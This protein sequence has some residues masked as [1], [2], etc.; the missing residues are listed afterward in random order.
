MRTCRHDVCIRPRTG[1]DRRAPPGQRPERRAAVP[2]LDRDVDRAVERERRHDRRQRRRSGDPGTGRCRAG[3]RVRALDPAPAT[4]RPALLD[5]HG[6][7][8]VVGSIDM[9]HAFA[10]QVARGLGAVV[11]AVEY[12]LA[13]EHPFPAGVED[14]YAALQWMHDDAVALGIDTDRI[15]VGGQSAG[16]GLTAATVLLARDRG[17]PPVCFQFLGIPELDHRLETTSMRTFVDTPMWHRPNAEK[18]WRYYLGPDARR[19]LAVRV[20]RDR[21]RPQRAPAGLRDDHG[22]RPAPRRRHHL[23]V[24]DDGGGCVRGVALLPGNVPRIRGRADGRGL[25]PRPPGAPRRAPTRARWRSIDIARI[26]SLRRFDLGLQSAGG[27]IRPASPLGDR[28]RRD[29]RGG[30]RRIDRSRGPGRHQRPDRSVGREH[31]ALAARLDD[32][33]SYDDDHHHQLAAGPRAAVRRDLLRRRALRPVHRSVLVPR[34]PH[35]GNVQSLRRHP[36]DLSPGLLRD[37]AGR[38]VECGGDVRR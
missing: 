34:P 32:D 19:G 15:A 22:V 38:P 20:A 7:G 28:G 14:C 17:G 25:A 3:A 31:H 5:I 29:D 12:R 30:R 18:S 26:A 11:V 37:L 23:R 24:A 4:G 27:T 2:S 16:G 6:G 33:C 36:V 21:D 9:E 8:F 1:S 13:P 35:R 10:V